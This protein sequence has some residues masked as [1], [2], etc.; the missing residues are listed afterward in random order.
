MNRLSLALALALV[1]GM[2][3][4]GLAVASPP[5]Q[6]AGLVPAQDPVADDA[7]ILA[8]DAAPDATNIDLWMSDT[9]DGQQ[10]HSVFS[11]TNHLWAVASFEDARNER[12]EVVLRDLSGIIVKR[13][14]IAANGTVTKSVPISVTDFINTYRGILDPTR[15]DGDVCAS[16]ACVMTRSLAEAKLNCQS[17][18]AAP[19]TWPEPPRPTVQPGRPTPTPDPA[20]LYRPY[21]LWLDSTLGHTATGRQALAEVTRTHQA[22]LALPDAREN[23]QIA[24]R[25]TQAQARLVDT[26]NDLG[27]VEHELSPPT[28]Q[29]SVI[30][31]CALVDEAAASA[32]AA[33]AAW[34]MVAASLTNVTHWRL[35]PTTARWAGDRFQGCIQYQTDL[36]AAGGGSPAVSVRWSVGEP[37]T[38]RLIFP[39][40]D[41]VDRG[42]EGELGVQLP[43]GAEAIYAQS[44]TAPGA[45]HEATIVAYVTDRSCIP[46]DGQQIVFSVFEPPPPLSA[47]LLRLQRGGALAEAGTVSPMTVTIRD[48]LATTL[49]QAGQDA[50]N[51]PAVVGEV[52]TGA[53]GPGPSGISATAP[54]RVIGTA[55]PEFITFLMRRDRLINYVQGDTLNFSI[56]A[57]DEF[58]RDVANGSQLDVSIP[59]SDPAVIAY[60]R[61]P[62]NNPPAPQPTPTPELVVV[63]K[64][65]TMSTHAGMSVLPESA[66]PGFRHIGPVLACTGEGEVTLSAVIDGVTAN[67][68]DENGLKTIN[69]RAR[70]TVQLPLVFMKYD[71]EATERPPRPI[72]TVTPAAVAPRR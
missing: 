72:E 19:P 2:A 57:R 59:Q 52:A 43:E 58:G 44:V 49:L 7:A 10:I 37:S 64:E 40:P 1:F 32:E 67:T 23:P 18:P 55:D 62:V 60:Y 68:N 3:V 65:M 48:G 30:A 27:R 20:D 33:N 35:P 47:G 11:T 69:C 56:Q 54:F 21:R 66:D 70:Y 34:A 12:Y 26:F 9:E 6:P 45:N 28:G 22:F 71:L 53:P 16:E 42:S 5:R 25:V 14:P 31:G 36:V 61:R 4:V 15:V 50:H 24:G 46:V 8:A 51:R 39:G 41:Q 13:G 63:G 29:P 38:P 17:A